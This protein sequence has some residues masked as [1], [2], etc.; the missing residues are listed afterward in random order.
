MMTIRIF[1]IASL[2]IISSQVS[3]QGDKEYSET[4]K[5][6]FKVSG[7]EESYQTAINQMIT[8]FK[9]QYSNVESD[10]WDEL[11]KEFSKTSIIELTEMLIPVYSKYLTIND[12]QELIRF[13]ETPVGKKFAKNSP[14]IIQESMQ[15]GQ[16]W[17]MKIGQD[18]ETKMKERGY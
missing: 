13:Y 15:I 16:Q 9:K 17:G 14:L 1:I 5:K 4:L 7:Y 18:I 3:G 8:M 12:L 11:E 2:F 10:V 6:M